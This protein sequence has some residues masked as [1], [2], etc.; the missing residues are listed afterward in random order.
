MCCHVVKCGISHLLPHFQSLFPAFS[1]LQQ[2]TKLQQRLVVI[3]RRQLWHGGHAQHL[4]SLLNQ[5]Q[6]SLPL[7]QTKEVNR[8]VRRIRLV[9]LAYNARGQRHHRQHI[10]AVVVENPGQLTTITA[11]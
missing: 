9:E 5:T 1:A 6:V 7:A 2:V 3:L 10:H 11:L 4:F 8:V